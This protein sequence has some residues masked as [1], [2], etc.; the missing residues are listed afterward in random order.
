MVIL[1]EIKGL[2]LLGNSLNPSSG[3]EKVGGCKN[4]RK[5]K[6]GDQKVTIDLSCE[7][8]FLS[9]R[10]LLIRSERLSNGYQSE[11][12]PV[13]RKIAG[14]GFLSSREIQGVIT[15]M[16]HTLS[17]ITA[18]VKITSLNSHFPLRGLST[19]FGS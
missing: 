5:E 15:I 10:D 12:K 11:E 1:V 6:K 9:W 4:K 17:P 8:L 7:H 19:E 3:S 14:S 18:K 13:N 16:R 2:A